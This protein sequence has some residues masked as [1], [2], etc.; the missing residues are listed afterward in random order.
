MKNSKKGFTLV[1][2]LVVI[3]IL[4]ILA[5][6]AVVGYT[7]FIDKANL[8]N[9]QVAVGQMNTILSTYLEDEKEISD[10]M[11]YLRAN[12]F[13]YEKMV[14]FSRGFHYCYDKNTN[15]MY[16][17]N[18]KDEIVFP[19]DSDVELSDLWAA[20][21]DH[22]TY[23]IPGITQYYAIKAV[24]SQEEF[25]SAFKDGTAY[26]LDLNDNICTVNGKSN[27]TV[28]N[29]HVTTT[30][31]ADGSDVVAVSPSNENNTVTT[32]DNEGKYTKITYTNVLNPSGVS[33]GATTYADG[34]TVEYVNCVFTTTPPGFYQNGKSLNL[35]FKNCSFVNIANFAVILQPGEDAGKTSTVTFDGCEFINC[36]RGIHISAWE[37]TTV[38]VTNCTFALKTGSSAY[39]CIQISVYANDTDLA[40]LK[41]NFTN[42]TVASANGV[43]YFHDAMTGPQN[44][45]TLKGVLNFSGNTYAK[46]VDLIADRGEYTEGHILY[47]NEAGKNILAGLIK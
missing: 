32:K 30:G 1:E 23:M 2:L 5:T 21:G 37:N 42:N 14:T 25:N 10:V 24:T 29:G 27:V 18:R 26:V 13:T 15:R 40:G 31:F 17:V 9:D 45:E 4:A 47:N 22:G 38:N 35:T 12:G 3:A 46:D 7:S 43:V 11:A 41:V 8:S 34:C 20:Y 6:V 16:L 33:S 36:N 44:I 39:N 28:K 19:E